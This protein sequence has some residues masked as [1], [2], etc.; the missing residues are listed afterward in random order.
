[1]TF[2]RA[3]LRA[4]R[5]AT[6]TVRVYHR[7]G[8]RDASRRPA[9]RACAAGRRRAL[10]G[11]DGSAEL[12]VRPL[13]PGTLTRRGGQAR[14]DAR[15]AERLPVGRL[16][17]RR[18][19]RTAAH[20]RLGRR[21]RA[22]CCARRGCSTARAAAAARRSSRRGP[23]G[24]VPLRGGADLRIGLFRRPPREVSVAAARRGPHV[25]ASGARRR[26]GRRGPRRG[27][28]ASPAPCRAAG[29]SSSS[30]IYPDG[31][32]AQLVTRTRAGR[33]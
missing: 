6:I 29:G 25:R 31:T 4:G 15:R 9:R 21:R 1:M 11:E 3:T 10:T 5:P 2:A 24:C 12:R 8:G 17:R 33:C 32:G 19:L 18:A 14:A 16:D 22:A 30:L 7:F 28:C 26:S 13:T 20:Q 23:R 27:A